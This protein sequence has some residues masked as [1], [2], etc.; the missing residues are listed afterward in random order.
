MGWLEWMDARNRRTLERQEERFS[1]YEPQ[2]PPGPARAE[3]LLW[4]ATE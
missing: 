2:D 3:A 4:V 1:T